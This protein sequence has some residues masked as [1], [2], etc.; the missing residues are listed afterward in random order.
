[1]KEEKIRFGS[2]QNLPMHLNILPHVEVLFIFA[3]FSS[4]QVHYLAALME[5]IPFSW[6]DPNIVL[7]SCSSIVKK[8]FSL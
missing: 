5:Y 1:M 4:R 2:I 7:F 3:Y 6:G 8:E